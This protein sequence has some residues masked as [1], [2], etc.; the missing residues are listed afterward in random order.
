MKKGLFVLLV[1]TVMVAIRLTYHP[2]LLVF[3]THEEKSEHHIAEARI[4]PGYICGTIGDWV[5]RFPKEIFGPIAQY[6]GD[7]PW[8]GDFPNPNRGCADQLTGRIFR[9][10][11]PGYEL[12]NFDS[13]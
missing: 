11:I 1:V 4:A 10:C 7:D 8:G 5:Y 3:L 9:M 6:V 13:R 2:E 12:V